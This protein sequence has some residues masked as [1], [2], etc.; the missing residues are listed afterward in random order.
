MSDYQYLEN[1]SLGQSVPDQEQF[2]KE[3]PYYSEADEMHLNFG[4]LLDNDI[5]DLFHLHEMDAEN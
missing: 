2:A 3:N 4:G 1:H 5:K